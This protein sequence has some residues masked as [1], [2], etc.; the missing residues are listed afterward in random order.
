MSTNIERQAKVLQRIIRVPYLAP[1]LVGIA[2][3]GNIITLVRPNYDWQEV[4]I[5]L[6]LVMSITGVV[7]WFCH[8]IFKKPA[9]AAFAAAL[10]IL[11]LAYFNTIASVILEWLVQSPLRFMARAAAIIVI[12][13]AIYTLMLWYFDKKF[14]KRQNTMLFCN[15]TLVILIIIIASDG[16]LPGIWERRSIIN[17]VKN[18]EF[19]LKSTYK[20]DVFWIIL[21]AYTS[22]ESLQKYWNYQNEDFTRKLEELGFHFIPNSRSISPATQES[23]ASTLNMGMCITT[24]SG[25]FGEYGKNSNFAKIRWSLVSQIFH[26]MGYDI[27]NLSLFR[28]QNTKMFYTYSGYGFN[29][30]DRLT[31]NSL[32]GYLFNIREK[33]KRKGKSPWALNDEILDKISNHLNEARTRPVFVYAH[34]MSPHPPYVYNSS[35]T[36]NSSISSFPDKWKYLDQLI[37]TNKRVV[38]TLEVLKRR[39]GAPPVIIIQGDHGSRVLALKDQS[40][41]ENT[42]II[43]AMY[44]PNASPSWFWNGMHAAD[45]FRLVFNKCFG[46]NYAYLSR[47][48]SIIETNRVARAGEAYTKIEAEK[49]N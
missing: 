31:H 8:R 13:G 22:N 25:K 9:T 41:D 29:M 15:W 26:E 37:Y 34:V 32:L 21:D 38:E 20:P 27:V 46:A 23:I 39:K 10:T 12:V 33:H 18:K 44:F 42:S 1:F 24:N 14:G 43:N 3:V 48:P 45:T 16:L 4:G 6:A 40:E 19:D 35:S 7:T 47:R 11:V 2:I 36:I 49:K 28:I 30:T 5:A 17:C